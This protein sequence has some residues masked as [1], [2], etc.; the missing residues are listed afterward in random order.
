[1]VVLCSLVTISYICLYGLKYGTMRSASWILGFALSFV[2]DFGVAITQIYILVRLR[3][4][5][6]AYVRQKS[7]CSALV[8]LFLI[9]IDNIDGNV[10]ERGMD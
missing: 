3:K 5:I 8:K 2:M 7:K 1:M 10:M 9:D 6:T 4:Q